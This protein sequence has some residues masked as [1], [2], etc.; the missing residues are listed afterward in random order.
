[1][2][3]EM[4]GSERTR[5]TSARTRLR[6]IRV[7]FETVRGREQHRLGERG[8]RGCRGLCRLLGLT[9]RGFHPAV[10]GATLVVRPAEAAVQATSDGTVEVGE[11]KPTEDE[12]PRD[13]RISPDKLRRF[14][15]TVQLDPSR[16]NRDFGRVAQEV[17]AHL[18]SLVDA[19]VEINVEVRAEHEEGFPDEVVRTVSENAKTLKFEIQ[20]VRAAVAAQLAREQ[21]TPARPHTSTHGQR[22]AAKSSGYQR[23]LGPE[24]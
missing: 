16:L 17:I 10:T 3:G 14:Y 1:M 22:T 11:Q 9:V 24:W 19:N 21:G 6:D 15:G 5:S 8:V 7:L 12:S 13:G 4:R 23:L 20:G 2:R 18:T